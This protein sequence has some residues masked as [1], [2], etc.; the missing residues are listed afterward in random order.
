MC[1]RRCEGLLTRAGKESAWSKRVW[2]IPSLNAAIQNKLGR[3]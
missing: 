1:H 2:S 3:S